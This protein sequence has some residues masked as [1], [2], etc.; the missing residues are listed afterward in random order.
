MAKGLDDLIEFLLGEI[1]VSGSR[2][3]YCSHSTAV[4][5]WPRVAPLQLLSL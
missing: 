4:L 2:G 1:A 5:G 3:Q